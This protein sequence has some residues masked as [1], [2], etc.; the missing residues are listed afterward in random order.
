MQEKTQTR[1]PR[2][3]LRLTN[4]VHLL[5]VGLGSGLLRLAPGTWGSLA[6]TLLGGLLLQGISQNLFLFLTALCFIAGCWICQKTAED[7]G[8]HDHG[9]IVWDEFVGIFMVLSVLPEVNWLWCSLGFVIFRV[10]DILKPY[11]I[12]YF[13]RKL[14]SGFG[15]MI[16]DVLAA[17]YSIIVIKGIVYLF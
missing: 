16:D 4:P 13:D 7:M 5:A 8:V 17:I 6:A 9:A 15:I 3:R 11:P 10:F 12:R 2:H 14:E 1:D